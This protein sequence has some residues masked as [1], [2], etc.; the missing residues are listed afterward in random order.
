M[1]SSYLLVMPSIGF[2]SHNREA[3]LQVLDQWFFK[4]DRLGCPQGSPPSPLL[5]LVAIDPLLHLPC[6]KATK[7]VQVMLA[8][9][10]DNQLR[11][12]STLQ[13]TKSM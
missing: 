7:V 1:G 4:P 13:G 11:N 6:S 9:S 12:L 8:Q 2:F 10:I 3:R 5:F